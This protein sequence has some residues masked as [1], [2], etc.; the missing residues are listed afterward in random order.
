MLNNP[1]NLRLLLEA[2]NLTIHNDFQ[3]CGANLGESRDVVKTSS[4][5]PVIKFS[6]IFMGSELNCRVVARETSR[7]Q[8]LLTKNIFIDGAPMA[9]NVPT[10]TKSST[11]DKPPKKKYSPPTLTTY[12][13]VRELTKQVGGTGTADGGTAPPFIKTNLP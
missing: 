10:D 5:S 11:A 7:Y 1:S 2:D 9:T 3:V 4:D 12:G 8:Y 13:T 6:G